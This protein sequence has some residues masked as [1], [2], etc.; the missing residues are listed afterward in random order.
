MSFSV[1]L[2]LVFWLFGFYF[3]W[4]VPFLE[5]EPGRGIHGDYLSIIIPAR[6]EAENLK[7]LLK[8]LDGQRVRAGE[9]IVVDDH[10]EDGTSDVAGEAGCVV[11][12]SEPL[13]ERWIGKPWACW[14]GAR[15]SKGSILLFLDADTRVEPNGIYKLL[16][17][18]YRHGGLLSVQPY[19]KMEKGYERLAAFFNIIT[20]AGMNAFT[21]L[22][23]RLKP[24]GAF[25][26]CNMC[27]KEAYFRT[28]GHKTVQG[29]ILESVGL[30]RAF[31]NHGLPVRCYGGKEAVTFRMYPDGLRSLVEGFSKGFGLGAKATT[32]AGQV[33]IFGWIYAQV[34][35][36]RH[37][38]NAAMGGN[39]EG[40]TIFA[41][42]NILYI[43]Q[44]H[45]MLHRIG[46]FRWI[47]ALFFQV[48]LLFFIGVFC[49]S[50][51]KTFV[52]RKAT[53]K[54]RSLKTKRG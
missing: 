25:G 54:G 13:P 50:L 4:R 33:L 6:N 19:H 30:G 49:V 23:K 18:Y 28:G 3:L 51:V 36:T 22:Q 31:L 48:P 32:T 16:A 15:R 1:V 43:L 11:L 14:Q 37:L 24:M 44:I 20:M 5:S 53:W 21:P 9:I 38:L 52:L 40:V 39:V 27:G 17:A 47:T 35:L 2:I 7:Y 34:H 10:S 45:W 41:G 26:P 8:S 12:H 29:D 42:L 46:N